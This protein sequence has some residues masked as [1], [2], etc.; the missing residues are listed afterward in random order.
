MKVSLMKNQRK[1]ADNQQCKSKNIAGLSS[2]QIF[3]R[4]IKKNQRKSVGNHQYKSKN[5]AGL[6]T[7]QI[8]HRSIK[9]H[10]LKSA[11]T[12]LLIFFSKI[13]TD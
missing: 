4:S 5:I 13:F 9:K 10:L 12:T 7:L 6:S 3:R 1:S 8:I 2:L 11:G